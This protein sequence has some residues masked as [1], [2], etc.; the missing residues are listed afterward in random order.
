MTGPPARLAWDRTL[1]EQVRCPYCN[2]GPGQPCRAVKTDGQPLQRFP[3]HPGR[4]LLAART[5]DE[6]PTQENP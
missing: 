4:T 6:Q 2:A 5:A 3:A 1:A